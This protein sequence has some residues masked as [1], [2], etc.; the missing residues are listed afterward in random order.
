MSTVVGFFGTQLD[1]GTGARRWERWRPTLSLFQQPDLEI[2]RLELLCPDPDA[3]AVLAEDVRGASPGTELVLVP[4]PLRDPWDFEEVYAALH[5]WVRA[6][7]AVEG[8]DL[9]VHLTT[10]THVAQI[11]LFL[12]VEARFL[13]GRL[14]QS[15]PPRRGEGPGTWQVIDLD[16]AR[17]DRIAQRFDVEREA[18]RSALKGGIDTRDPSY[19]ALV[20]RIEH[21]ATASTAPILL[22]GPTGAGKSRLARRIYE[23]KKARRQLAGPLCEVNCATLRGDQVSSTLFGHRRGAFTG[24]VENRPGLLLTAHGGMVFLDE[25]G[26]LGLDEQAMLLRAVEERRF[27]PVGADREVESDFQLVAG[28]NRDLRARVREGRFREDLLA[29]IDLWTF[30]LPSLRERL[31]DLEPNLDH[32]LEQFAR[33]AGRRVAMNREARDRFLAFATGPHGRWQA[34]FRDLAAAV[35]R[36]ATLSTSGRIGV[37][38]VEEEVGRLRSQWTEGPPDDLVARVLGAAAAELDR[39][40]RVQLD[41]VLRVCLTSRSLSDAGRTLF[42]AS[43]ARRTSVN[44]ADRL[45]KYLARFELDFEQVHARASGA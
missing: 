21:V 9:L 4:F 32:E 6:R 41:D 31:A 17:Y 39:F 42:A 28:T 25:I 27:L 11:C 3:A 35:T 12:L 36:M 30:R 15:G 5:D 16:L 43:R 1:G 14:L 24:A 19:N 45:R 20:E 22:T 10:G 18:S 34:N 7:P 38:A 40:D 26:E 8:E 37:E 33:R 13:P 44:D 2:G 23:L 29:R